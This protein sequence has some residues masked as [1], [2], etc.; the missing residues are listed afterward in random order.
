M[1]FSGYTLILYPPGW[2]RNTAR[3]TRWTSRWHLNHDVEW[4]Q[5]QECVHRG[6]QW[7]TLPF[8][9]AI[10]TQSGRLNSTTHQLSPSE[11]RRD[12]LLL[13]GNTSVHIQTLLMNSGLN[14]MSD[15]TQTEFFLLLLLL[16]AVRFSHEGP[17]GS[18]TCCFLGWVKFWSTL[19]RKCLP[20][21]KPLC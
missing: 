13:Q 14:Y 3:I 7:R 15:Y 2:Q 5:W 16:S 1:L 4:Q 9:A 8:N 18:R 19:T 6:T 20:S 11:G 12:E 17:C 10:K 21:T